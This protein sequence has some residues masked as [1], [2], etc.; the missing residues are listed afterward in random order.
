EGAST[1]LGSFGYVRC[2]SEIKEQGTE[3]GWHFDSTIVAVGSGGTMAGLLAGAE[4]FAL[5]TEIIGVP[6]CDDAAHFRPVVGSILEG[7][8]DHY[9]PDISTSVSAD[10]LVD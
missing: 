7:L 9:L 1:P 5:G 2:C 4:A 6:V 3:A 8:K 10:A